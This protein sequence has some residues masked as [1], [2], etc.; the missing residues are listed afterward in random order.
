[1]T[2]LYVAS[3]KKS[4]SFHNIGK[5]LKAIS[6]FQIRQ[7]IFKYQFTLW[8]VA[9][10][11]PVDTNHQKPWHLNSYHEVVPISN[12]NLRH[13][14]ALVFQLHIAI[15][16]KLDFYWF[17]ICG[18]RPITNVN[19]LPKLFWPT[20]RKNCSSDRENLLKVEAEGRK[21]FR[22]LDKFTRTVKGQNNLW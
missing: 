17:S 13:F 20:V 12:C 22:S 7:T 10:D 14:F 9:M 18:T 6:S 21:F 19:L 15:Q 5:F 1:M 4:Y 8:K 3:K 16:I 2:H 11:D